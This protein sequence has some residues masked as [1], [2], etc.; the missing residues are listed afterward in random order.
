MKSNHDTGRTK[1]RTEPNLEAKICAPIYCTISSLGRW[2]PT[3]ISGRCETLSIWNSP[4]H[5]TILMWSSP[6]LP[7]TVFDAISFLPFLLPTLEAVW[8]AMSSQETNGKKARLWDLS[9]LN[10]EPTGSRLCGFYHS[11]DYVFILSDNS[12]SFT[13]YKY[14][15]SWMLMR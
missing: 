14:L 8:F 2:H 15:R 11:V 6:A 5:R 13:V 4:R 7:D 10:R 12:S 9:D 3:F 1:V